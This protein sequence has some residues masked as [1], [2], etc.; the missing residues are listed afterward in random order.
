MAYRAAAVHGPRGILTRIVS[1]S[2]SLARPELPKR[3]YREAAI[4]P[5]NGGHA[6]LLDGR[7]VRTPARKPLVLP[8]ERPAL[9]VAAEWNAQGERVNPATMPVTR[10]A[11]T[12]VDGI[13]DD[14][15]PVRHDLRRY[16]ETDLVFYRA[17]SPE[18]LLERQVAHWDPVLAWARGRIGHDFIRVEGV[19]HVAQ[20]PETLAAM[21]QWIDAYEDA[22]A[23]AALH[24]MATLTGSLLLALAVAERE[25]TIEKAWQAA[26]V[27]E[28][29]N[30]QQWGGD[31]EAQARRDARFEDM[32][33]AA[34][35]AQIPA[36][37]S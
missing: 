13:A 31:E 12:I 29:W 6:V 37:H 24:Q 11:N 28:D 36:N 23:V 18:R 30:T 14:P 15:A 25:L 21:S 10:L 7:P 9:A 4:A 1:M 27:D 26:H 17:E 8:A 35:F 34:L 33:A 32:K 3:F 5:A 19:M 16:A 20:P 2:H 22:F